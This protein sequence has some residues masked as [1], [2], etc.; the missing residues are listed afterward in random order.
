MLNL[1]L[2]IIYVCLFTISI[3][4]GQWHTYTNSNY[5]NDITQIQDKLYCATKGGLTVFNK[6]TQAFVQVFTNTDGLPQNQCLCIEHDRTDNLWIGTDG[7]GLAVYEP[8]NQ[9][10]KTYQQSELPLRIKCILIASDTILIGSENGFY[11]IDTKGTFTIHSDDNIVHFSKST[12]SL[13]P[14]DNIISVAFTDSFFWFGTNRGLARLSRDTSL[15]LRS[16]SRPFGNSV[17]AM[18]VISDSLF[19][20]TEAGIAKFNG[21]VFDTI[22]SLPSQ[23]NDSVKDMAYH[24]NNFFLAKNKGLIRFNRQTIDTIW[25]KPTQSLIMD[26]LLFCGMGEEFGAGLG[27]RAVYDT[28]DTLWKYFFSNGLITNNIVSLITSKTGEIYVCHD[29]QGLSRLNTT[30][31]WI[32]LYSP[33]PRA[34]VLS[35]DRENRIW[36]GH[37]WEVGAGGLSFY[38]PQTDNWG[39]VQWGTSSPRNVIHALG[40]DRNDTK[41]VWNKENEVIAIDNNGYEIVLKRIDAPPGREGSYEFAFDSKNRVWLG[42]T[43]G[44][45]MLDYNGTLFN[46]SDDRWE[47]YTNLPGLQGN[48]IVSLAI[49]HKDRVWIGT[50]SGSGVLDNGKFTPIIPPLSNDIKKVRVDAW[51]IVWFLTAEGLLRYNPHSRKWTYYTQGNLGYNK[52]IPNPNQINTNFYTSLHIDDRNGFLLLGTQAGLSRFDLQDSSK[53]NLSAVRVY[54]NPCIYIKGVLGPESV[55]FDSLPTGSKVLI[56]TLSGKLL[57]ELK[58]NYEHQTK[59]DVQDCSSG[60]YLAVI[61]SPFGT[62]VEKFAVIR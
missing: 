1:K 43:Q 22:L 50:A 30:G 56:Y 29:A 8:K 46:T 62:R 47:T 31:Y 9:I 10:F 33:L 4:F 5:I 41:W 40:I 24:W 48:E 52:I 36:L 54:P 61:I 7:A 60:I 35:K 27:L 32:H 57:T 14:S 39:T 45:L 12:D 3:T 34:R 28:L 25:G 59:F 42:T 11:I 20:A 15:T 51:G 58:V 53:P 16:F 6:D 26:S 37:F 17:Q 2:L 23:V 19:I 21:T 18:V 13:M 49:D 38:D 55:T 44:L